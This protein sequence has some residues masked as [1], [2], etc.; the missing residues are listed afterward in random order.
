MPEDQLVENSVY[1]NRRAREKAS[2]R[3]AMGPPGRLGSRV[4]ITAGC[5]LDPPLDECF[6]LPGDERC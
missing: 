3:A 5:V 1:E 6:S 2:L 4:S